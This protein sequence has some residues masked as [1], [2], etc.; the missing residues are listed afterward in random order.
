MWFGRSVDLRRSGD[1]VV[2]SLSDCFTYGLLDRDPDSLLRVFRQVAELDAS[3]QPLETEVLES[4]D[5]RLALR[6]DA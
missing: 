5:V 1:C 3:Y 2:L 6:D 4:N